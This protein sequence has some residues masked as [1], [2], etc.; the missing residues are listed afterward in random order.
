MV[1]IEQTISQALDKTGND[2]YKLSVLVFSRVKELSNGAK[3]LLKY[4]EEYLKCMEPCDIALT[5]IAEGKITFAN[6]L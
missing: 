4:S 1:R 3:P 6:P 5:E 2:R